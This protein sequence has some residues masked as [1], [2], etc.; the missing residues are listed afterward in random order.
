MNFVDPVHELNRLAAQI[1]IHEQ[2]IKK[3]QKELLD[4]TLE[5]DAIRVLQAKVSRLTKKLIKQYQRLAV[6]A[7]AVGLITGFLIA[8]ATLL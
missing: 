4:A 3:Q 8:S 6:L 7:A 1:R 5:V 2:T